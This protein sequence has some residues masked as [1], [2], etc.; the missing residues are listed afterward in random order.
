MDVWKEIWDGRMEGDMGWTGWERENSSVVLEKEISMNEEKGCT[1]KRV[2]E[3]AGGAGQ[4]WA[5]TISMLILLSPLGLNSSFSF[6]RNTRL[7]W[8]VSWRKKKKGK[9]KSSTLS[10]TFA[11][12]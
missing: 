7:L 2:D 3:W 5:H 10:T 12:R 1:P 8:S 11:R 9:S 6:S 4:R